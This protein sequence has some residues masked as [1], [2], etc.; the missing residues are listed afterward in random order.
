MQ[1]KYRR[2]HAFFYRVALPIF[3]CANL[4]L[5]VLLLTSV[6]VGGWLRWMSLGS[7][8]LCCVIAGWLSGVA[9]S[10]FHWSSAME[11]QVTRWH[12]VVDAVF[13]WIEEAPIPADALRTLKRS[14]DETLVR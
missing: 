14:L 1:A 7:G 13:G 8:V 3:V 10:S 4:S 2:R 5:G 9:W 11:R 6:Q 12:G